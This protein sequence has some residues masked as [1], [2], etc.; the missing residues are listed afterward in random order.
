M[1]A[2]ACEEE[3]RVTDPGRWQ[4]VP[5][6][7]AVRRRRAV[8]GRCGQLMQKRQVARVQSYVQAQ[9]KRCVAVPG[10]RRRRVCAAAWQRV[11]GA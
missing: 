10:A 5:P 7:G 1:R 4:A 8:E 3:G 2:T 6:F 11:E 9:R